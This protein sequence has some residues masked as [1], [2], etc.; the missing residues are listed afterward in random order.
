M[1]STITIL[2]DQDELSRLGSLNRKKELLGCYELHYWRHPDTFPS[3]KK[4]NAEFGTDFENAELKELLEDPSVRTRLIKKGVPT[5]PKEI[6]DRLTPRQLDWITHLLDHSDRK[7]LSAKCKAFG[8]TWQT[9]NAWMRNGLFRDTLRQETDRLSA[10]R[11]FEVVQGLINEASAG[12]IQAAKVYLEWQG[13]LKN[14]VN[15]NVT[16]E[17]KIVVH[18]IID[19]LATHVDPATLDIVG[20]ELDAV[21]NPA[22]QNR[23]IID[24]L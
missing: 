7:S 12:N 5:S 1:D 20:K 21:L 18:K 13:E 19:I 11:R 6:K 14:E 17:Y 16:H 15:V 2:D 3:P 9:H 23:N 10:D 24:L 4:I 22:P 8:I